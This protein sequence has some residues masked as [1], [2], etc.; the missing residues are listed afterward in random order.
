MAILVYLCL[1]SG[2]HTVSVFTYI[3]SLLI[4][5]DLCESLN[6]SIKFPCALLLYL[7]VSTGDHIVSVFTYIY[8]LLIDKDLRESQNVSIKFPWLF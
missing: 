6:K 5:K 7:C 8:S 4:D 2:D 1:S 3:Y